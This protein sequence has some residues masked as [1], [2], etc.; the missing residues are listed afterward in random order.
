M[1]RKINTFRT[2][3]EDELTRVDEA[4]KETFVNTVKAAYEYIIA[5]WPVDT[6]YSTAN[7]RIN[8]T[9]RPVVR[10]EPSQKPSVSGALAGKAQAVHAAQLAKLDRLTA[11]KKG[12]NVVIGNAVDYAPNV[13][14]VEGQGTAIYLEAARLGRAVGSRS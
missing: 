8:I 4:E 7:H 9:G 6:Y 12:R 11:E 2:Q 14:G 1:P 10:L 3:L 5:N 13:G